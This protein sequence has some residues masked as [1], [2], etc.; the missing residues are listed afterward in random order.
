MSLSDQTD[1]NGLAAAVAAHQKRS[2]DLRSLAVAAENEAKLHLLLVE[3]ASN[4]RLISVAKNYAARL[5]HDD[6][7]V[8]VNDFCANE[9]FEL[10]SQISEVSYD[11]DAGHLRIFA[12]VRTENTGIRI[13][14][15]ETTGNFRAK[16]LHEPDR[17]LLLA[18]LSYPDHS[19]TEE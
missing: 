12:N 16:P 13:V 5:Q 14:W 19:S 2:T 10:P 3:L 18:G 15:D 17:R 1:S 4:E 8:D 7:V 11:R 9:N 6:I